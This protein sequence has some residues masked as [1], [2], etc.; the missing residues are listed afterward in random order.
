MLYDGTYYY[1]Y[2]P[3]GNRTAQFKSSTGV[4]ESGAT[5]ITTYVWNDKNQLTAVNYQAA[6]GDTPEN[7]ATYTYDAF[8][9]VVSE[10]EAGQAENYVYDGQNLILVLNAAGQVTERE[11]NGPAAGGRE[12]VLATENVLAG[13]VNW[14]LS[15][16]QGTV[17]D[18]VQFNGSTTS[19]VDHLVYDSFGQITW[20]SSAI[21]QPRFTYTGQ[22]FDSASQLYYDN[23]RWYDAVNGVFASQDPLG[24]G[25]GDTNLS[26]YCGNSPTNATDPSG[27]FWDGSVQGSVPRWVRQYRKAPISTTTVVLTLDGLTLV[28]RRLGA[29]PPVPLRG[30]SP[31][32]A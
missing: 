13:T 22:R 6:Y 9:R 2:D 3:D 7:L 20:Q 28:E 26:R 23:A 30:H 12:G 31:V 27:R 14:L 19:V 32:P 24:F 1:T 11:L 5:E 29:W 17:R 4:L 10:T 8:G 21:N 15:D 25:G 16:N 18:V